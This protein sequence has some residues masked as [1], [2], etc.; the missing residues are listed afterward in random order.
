MSIN[1]KQSGVDIDAGNK[2]VSLIKDKVVATF[3]QNVIT[4]LGTFGAMYDLSSIKDM[5][6]PIL[7]QSIDGVGTKLKIATMM[8]K[9]TTVGHDIVNHCSDDIVCQGAKPISFLDYVAASNLKPAI[10]DEIVSGMAEACREAGVNL[11]GGETAEMPG[12]YLE[13]E[14]DIAGCITGVVEKNKV[15]TGDNIKKDDVLLGFASSGL[16]TNGYSLARKLFFEVG[17]YKVDSEIPELEKNVG[18]TLLAPHI[19]YT[20]PILTIIDAGINIK[21]IAHITGGGFIENIPR[22]LPENTGVEIN[23]GSWPIL[24]VFDVM[25]KLGEVEEMEMYRAFNMGIGMVIIVSS[26]EALKVNKKIKEFKDYKLYEIGK[27]IK[28]ERMVNLV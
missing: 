1:Y 16:H 4:G 12:V 27:V 26:E 24:P 17:R 25:Q 11:I 7:V 19:N 3:D 9:F 2:A 14:H 23:K 10:I 20:N 8:N 22:V 15:I 18:E 5:Q 6:Q 28:G 13:G 21:G